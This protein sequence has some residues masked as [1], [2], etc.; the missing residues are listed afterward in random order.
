M[1]TCVFGELVALQEGFDGLVLFVELSQVR[2]EVLD[3]VGVWQGVDAAFLC[4]AG[5]PAYIGR[6]V[7]VLHSCFTRPSRRRKHRDA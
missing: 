5:Y 4:F 6:H 2:D 3:D 1:G 7:S